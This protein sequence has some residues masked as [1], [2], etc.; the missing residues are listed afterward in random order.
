MSETRKRI[1]KFHPSKY[2][3]QKGLT[4]GEINTKTIIQGFGRNYKPL[5]SMPL[6]VK[7]FGFSF[8]QDILNLIKENGLYS[9]IQYATGIDDNERIEIIKKHID[10]D[11]PVLLAIGNGHIRRG[12]NNPILRF[13]VGHFITV[14][15]Y[16]DQ[17]KIFYI[18]DS[19]LKGNYERD[20]PVGNEVRTFQEFLQDWQ[21]PIYYRFIK[22]KHVYLPVSHKRSHGK[23]LI[24]PKRRTTPQ[25]GDPA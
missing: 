16:D 5:K 10:H 14:Y 9:T 25:A 20:I 8:V 21:G 15:G 2:K 11:E 1:V 24:T 23:P 22:M 13:L 6:R 18:Y 4:C 19:Y 12:E 3:T 17:E 7:I